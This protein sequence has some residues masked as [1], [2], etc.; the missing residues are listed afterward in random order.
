[1]KL[2][3][4]DIDPILY[5]PLHILGAFHKNSFNIYVEGPMYKQPQKD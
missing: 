5:I 1:M 3:N 2:I 4:K